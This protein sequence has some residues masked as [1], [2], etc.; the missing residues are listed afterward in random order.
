[1]ELS[2]RSVARALLFRKER[3]TRKRSALVIPK[4]EF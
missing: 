4:F 3:D 2:H 1:M